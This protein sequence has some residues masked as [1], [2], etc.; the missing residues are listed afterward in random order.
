MSVPANPSEIAREVFRLIATRR[1]APT[2]DNYRKLYDEV[3]G[4][5]AEEAFPERFVRSLARQLPRDTAER[6]RLARNLDQALGSGSPETAREAL[7]HYLDSLRQDANPAWNELIASLLRQWDA[8]HS[9][10]TT[11]RKRESLDRV[12]TANDPTTLFTRLQGLLRSWSQTPT[13]SEPASLAA[14][15]EPASAPAHAPGAAGGIAP[16]LADGLRKLLTLALDTVVPAVLGEFPELANEAA[17]YARTAGYAR[18]AD[19]F[20]QLAAQLRQFAW[21]LELVTGDN[22]EVHAGLLNLF[23]LLLQN[24]DQIVVDDRWLHGQIEVLRDIIDKPA[25]VRMIDDAE[26]RLKEVIYKQS[27]LKHNLAE[28]Q[29]SIK[30]M[31]AGFID[32]FARLAESTGSHH[33]RMGECA[34]RIS[35]ARD[36]TEIGHVL[37]EVM[38]ETRAIQL[39]AQ[40]SRDDLHDARQRA[41]DAEARI[42]QLQAELDQT[43]RLMR[44][45]QLTGTLN[46][47]GLEEAFAREVARA[48]RRQTPLCLAVLDL[49]HFKR[50]N[51]TWGHKTG[52]DA[53]VHLTTVIRHSLR[54]QDTVARFGGEEFI[55]I[56]PETSLP[57]AT[58]ALVRLQRELTRT[59][60][61]AGDAK[62]LITFSAGVTEWHGE[63]PMDT[64][65]KR[66]DAA[67]YEAKRTGRNK[68]VAVSATA[69]A[70]L[71]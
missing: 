18:S 67:M 42:A 49:D 70:P 44:H 17:G 35:A 54:P 56:Y 13:G 3:A 27:Q 6:L 48:Q 21:R 45:D 29:R 22:A 47:R 37:D 38:R 9:G 41:V 34:Q 57:D 60:F 66:A 51:D 28:A 15:T 65:L 39:Q 31:L 58:A 4:A 30:E 64:I 12:L 26:R 8:R 71:A 53:L 14:E 5:P 23:R 68:V 63:E 69:A 50:L 40:R 36:I 59:F 62:V 16:E 25:N 20:T 7:T 32:Q 1:I 24:I 43:S 61:L 46:R 10:W 2:P 52:D 55:L 19:D 11:A 33:D